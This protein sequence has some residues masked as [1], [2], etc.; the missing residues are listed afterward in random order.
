VRALDA[1]SEDGFADLSAQVPCCGVTTS[2]D[3]LDYDWSCA[4]ARFRIAVRNP[5]RNRFT[6]QELTALAEALGHPVRQVMAHI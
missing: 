1:H 4:F 3:A 5:G 2:L 6:A